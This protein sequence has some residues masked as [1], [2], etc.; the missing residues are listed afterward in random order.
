MI[1]TVLRKK[2]GGDLLNRFPFVIVHYYFKDLHKTS[3]STP[4]ATIEFDGIARGESPSIITVNKDI[5][6]QCV[7]E[8]RW[9]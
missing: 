6:R 5:R 2:G 1:K 3:I 9:L 4:K 7:F 8:S